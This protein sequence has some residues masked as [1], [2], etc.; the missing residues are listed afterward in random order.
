M[1]RLKLCELIYASGVAGLTPGKPLCLA[2]IAMVHGGLL[3]RTLRW[4][5]HAS[6]RFSGCTL[7]RI[8]A[9]HFEINS[10]NLRSNRAPLMLV[11]NAAFRGLSCLEERIYV[12]RASGN[13]SGRDLSRPFCLQWNV[14]FEADTLKT[15]CATQFSG[16]A[17]HG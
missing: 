10:F 15:Q 17:T 3:S 5:C 7:C 13:P 4:R 11:A 14:H 9:H 6:A 1:R 12:D 16:I 2:G 8:P